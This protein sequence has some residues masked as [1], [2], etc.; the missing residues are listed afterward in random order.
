MQ[1]FFLFSKQY[2]IILD[3]IPSNGELGC[4]KERAAGRVKYF[5]PDYSP[6]PNIFLL[7]LENDLIF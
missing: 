7:M 4:E 6:L 3:V 2:L 5:L 1:K